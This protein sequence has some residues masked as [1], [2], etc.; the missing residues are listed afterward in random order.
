M[1]P[2]SEAQ[3]TAFTTE[4]MT[5]R[6]RSFTNS[7]LP[8]FVQKDS[9]GARKAIVV[10]G[11]TAVRKVVGGDDELVMLDTPFP[12][13]SKLIVK[14]VNV[15]SIEALRDTAFAQVGFGFG[16]SMLEPRELLKQVG[17][18][19][20]IV[21]T[22]F[23]EQQQVSFPVRAHELIQIHRVNSGHIVV[24]TRDEPITVS[25]STLNDVD[26]V[27]PYFHLNGTANGLEVVHFE[28]GAGREQ[29]SYADHEFGVDYGHLDEF[30]ESGSEQSNQNQI[31]LR[32]QRP[33][34]RPPRNKRPA[35]RPPTSHV[36]D[37]RT[38]VV[39]FE[40]EIDAVLMDC[41]HMNTCNDCAEV[42][43][44]GSGQC[45]I[46]RKPIKSIIKVFVN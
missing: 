12:I 31:P 30:Y 39:C 45:P 16:V 35:P 23:T 43:K 38:C 40:K 27:Y 20:D 28:K 9:P 14:V 18:S 4:A 6:G 41:R 34:P 32:P 1:D 5:S 10:Q 2:S 8:W 25:L 26:H 15:V 19:N 11:H 33:A 17:H 37:D 46:C 21:D 42:I 44:A 7:R 36:R 13:N 24:R 22:D 29:W 3:E